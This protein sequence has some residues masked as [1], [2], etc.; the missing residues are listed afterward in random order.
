[1]LE[2]VTEQLTKDFNW[3]RLLIECHRFP[4]V[5]YPQ[6]EIDALFPG[7]LLNDMSLFT[8]NLLHW[9]VSE[10]FVRIILTWHLCA[11]SESKVY[12]CRINTNWFLVSRWS[13]AV[14]GLA[15]GQAQLLTCIGTS[16]P[17]SFVAILVRIYSNTK[18]IV[19][20]KTN[21]KQKVF[22]INHYSWICHFS[23]QQIP[24]RI[25]LL[26]RISHYVDI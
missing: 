3:H 25:S 6:V 18:E 15:F 16:C 21:S 13:R 8:K 5:C 2:C 26:T 19:K 17:S 14:I 20:Q 4:W 23:V 24:S 11:C 12:N 1:M 22:I 7:P 9:S 10:T